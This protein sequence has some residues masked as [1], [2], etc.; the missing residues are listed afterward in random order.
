MLQFSDPQSFVSVDP[1]WD[2]DP[3]RPDGYHKRGR[4][5][6]NFMFQRGFL[7]AGGFFSVW[8]SYLK[9][10]KIVHFVIKSSRV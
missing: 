5:K 2:S 4:K 7:K 8:P 1:D 3:G 9:F 6:E 10:L